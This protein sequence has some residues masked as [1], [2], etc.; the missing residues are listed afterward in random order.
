MPEY[1][2]PG[3]YV[4]EIELGPKPIEGVSTSTAGFLGEAERGPT[5]P[6]LVTSWLDYQRHFGGFFGADKYLPYAVQ[7]FFS[8][9]GKRCY[10]ARIVRSNQDAPAITASIK[11]EDGDGGNAL[12]LQAVG[13][14]EWGN[15]I[16]VKVEA[17]TFN[18]EAKPLFKLTAQ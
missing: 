16:Y 12:T 13:E 5:N 1:L 11:L 10:I 18:T 9:G 7:G 15:R 6:R 4:E 8:N 3:V 17:A 2:A 14:G